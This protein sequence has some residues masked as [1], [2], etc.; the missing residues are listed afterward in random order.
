MPKLKPPKNNY[1]GQAKVANFTCKEILPKPKYPASPKLS[2]KL[3]P[4]KL[5][6]KDLAKIKVPKAGLVKKPKV[7]SVKYME[8]VAA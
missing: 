3:I 4:P 2:I 7:N 5:S 1:P 6:K 8:G